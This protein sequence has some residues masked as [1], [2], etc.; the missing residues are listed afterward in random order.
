[1]SIQ[2]N[3][4]DDRS[5]SLLKLLFN[6][7]KKPDQEQ[8]ALILEGCKQFAKQGGLDRSNNELLPLIWENINSKHEE[9]RCLVAESCAFQSVLFFNYRLYWM[10][11]ATD[12]TIE[13]SSKVL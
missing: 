9:I 6:L 4:N 13:R 7:I 12:E 3:S 11:Y 8:R 5:N 1:M 10:L 2:Q